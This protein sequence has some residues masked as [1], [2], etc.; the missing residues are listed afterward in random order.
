MSAGRHPDVLPGY[1]AGI[2]D[3]AEAART[4]RHVSRCAECRSEVLTLTGMMM[5]LRAQHAIGHVSVEDL[6]AYQ[7]DALRP[8]LGRRA[9]VEEHLD[10]CADCREDLHALR[11]VRPSEGRRT[12][13]A[14]AAG[15]RRWWPVAAAAA[16]IGLP[17]VGW[18]LARRPHALTFLPNHRG[19]AEERILTE[20][21]TWSI[22][23]VLPLDASPG[24]YRSRAERADGT[25]CGAVSPPRVA[26]EDGR[27]R[28][29]LTPGGEPG[30]CRLVLDFPAAAPSV[31]HEYWFRISADA[32]DV[33]R[34]TPR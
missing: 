14:G 2:L 16:L 29:L 17:W 6:V 23:V 15:N 9:M 1:V 5:A 3:P 4:E 8:D 13:L 12:P 18:M 27:V 11:R 10:L 33:R 28:I 30:P 31:E 7:S 32:A 20:G 21:D 24:V 22:T 25:S 34:G 26:S 19:A